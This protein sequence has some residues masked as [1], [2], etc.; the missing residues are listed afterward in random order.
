M[1]FLRENLFLAITGAVALLGGGG[2]VAL[3]L[4]L[5]KDVNAAL[6][7][8][9]E[10][11]DNL[12]R[13]A[14]GG[15]ANAAMVEAAEKRVEQVKAAVA[16]VDQVGTNWN[17]ANFEV[18]GVPDESGKLIPAF[19]ITDETAYRAQG[20]D[21]AF[22]RAYLEE[23]NQLL[24]SLKPTTSP[25]DREIDSQVIQWETRL[26]LQRQ[27]EAEKLRGAVGQGTYQPS[28]AAGEIAQP[29]QTPYGGV[30]G[31]GGTA[32]EEAREKGLR[33]AMVN[34]AK[35]GVVYA[36]PSSLDMYFL[37]EVP[38]RPLNELWQAQ[39]NLWVTGDIIG[40]IKQTNQEVLEKLPSQDRNVL[41]AAIKHLVKIDVNENYARAVPEQAAPTPVPARRA[42]P[43]G[44]QFYEESE[45]METRAPAGGQAMP[46]AEGKPDASV[47]TRR[48]SCK[49]YDVIQYSFTVVMSPRHLAALEQNL[50]ARNYH[51]ITGIQV[52][53]IDANGPSALAQGAG[54]AYSTYTPGTATGVE[55]NLFYYGP[56]TV[57]QVRLEGELL[58]LAA[59]ER[60]TWD[61]RNKRFDP[62]LPPLVPVEA[63]QQQFPVAD[64][65]A[66]RPEDIARLPQPA[67]AP[68]GTESAAPPSE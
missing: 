33:A 55:S 32:S 54:A 17:R 45:L 29:L 48:G 43:A 47:L 11:A 56:D 10:L 21:Y 61:E 57:A 35:A 16:K 58:L 49:D 36:N 59:W 34:K 12:S 30:G 20:L 3:H 24:A 38:N 31:L 53:A 37:E 51:T 66:L 52:E 9:R 14:G 15:G 63:L 65:P 64:D 68:E 44:E 39:L 41:N 25:T 13:L 18:L 40:A 28:G 1:R 6:A 27:A 60:G 67:A 62:K 4:R 23:T 8:R 46:G 19:P 5:A 22:T 2:M 26:S 7:E 42:G 50:M